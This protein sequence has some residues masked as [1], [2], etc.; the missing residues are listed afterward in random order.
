MFAHVKKSGNYQYLK[1][2]E[3]RKVKIKQYIKWLLT[4]L[5]KHNIMYVNNIDIQYVGG[6]S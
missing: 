5:R 4:S 1:I 3:M 6:K 2:I